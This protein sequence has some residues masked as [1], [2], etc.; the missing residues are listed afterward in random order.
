MHQYYHITNPFWPKVPD[1]FFKIWRRLFCTRGIHLFDEE[2]TDTEQSYLFCDA[3][4][5][6]VKIAETQQRIEG[7]SNGDT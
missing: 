2:L 3:C 6:E 1:R 7:P 4:F 5:L